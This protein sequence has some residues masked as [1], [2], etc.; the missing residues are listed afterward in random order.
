MSSEVGPR[1]RFAAALRLRRTKLR[2]SIADVAHAMNVKV[3]SLAR[4]EKEAPATLTTPERLAHLREGYGYYHLS[5][6]NDDSYGGCVHGGVAVFRQ[7]D[8]GK[9]IR[10]IGDNSL[11]KVSRGGMLHDAE[12]EPVLVTIEPKG[13]TSESYDQHFGEEILYVISGTLSLCYV[14]ASGAKA[15]ELGCGEMAHY[16]GTT[17]HKLENGGPE[18]ATAILIK[19]P[20]DRHTACTLD[21]LAARARPLAERLLEADGET[22]EEAAQLTS[23]PADTLRKYMEWERDFAPAQ[24]SR[25]GQS[26]RPE[27]LRFL[28]SVILRWVETGELLG[29]GERS[30]LLGARVAATRLARGLGTREVAEIAGVKERE[31]SS[32]ENGQWPPAAVEPVLEKWIAGQRAAAR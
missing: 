23:L 28:H 26:A 19:T 2:L 27:S 5:A 4:W 16:R 29:E 21:A 9:T 7:R 18:M 25:G 1:Q 13:T 32:W 10:A 20:P 31:V 3:A 12:L 17:P 11:V 24:A 30:R 22:F 6:E 14:D 15:V 8:F